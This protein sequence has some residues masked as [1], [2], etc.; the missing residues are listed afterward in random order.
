MEVKHLEE[1]EFANH[2]RVDNEKHPTFVFVGKLRFYQFERIGCAS[3]LI[4]YLPVNFDRFTIELE[5]VVQI[6]VRSETQ[7]NINGSDAYIDERFY[8]MTN[9]RLVTELYHWFWSSKSERTHLGGT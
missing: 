5:E 3:R 9:D 1:W 4:D 2:V 8:L 6:L 7:D